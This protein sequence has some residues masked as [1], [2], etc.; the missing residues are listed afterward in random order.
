MDARLAVALDV[1][2][3]AR[4]GALAAELAAEVG[5][6]KIGLE[7]FTREGPGIVRAIAATGAR[8]FLDLKFHDIPNTVERAVTAAAALPGVAYLTLHVAGGRAMLEAAVRARDACGP[9]AP[10]LLGVTVLTSLDE[11]DLRA[12]GVPAAPHEQTLR[13]ARLAL[14]A[15]LDGL[16]CAASEVAALRAA[17]G[18][19]PILVVPGI[20]PE[21]SAPGDQKRTAT[22]AAALREGASLLVVGR[23]ITE[24]A[25]PRD[26]ARA[27]RCSL[28]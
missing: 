18:P 2:D 3:G 11:S 22:P 12:T 20:R 8:I 13:L 17:C 10:A 5:V 21:G 19:D 14:D 4:A 15:G 26:A 25:V 23:P 27:L 28:P 7:L 1:A 9:Q 16:V 6:F 24:A